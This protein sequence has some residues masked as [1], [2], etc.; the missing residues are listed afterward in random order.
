MGDEVGGEPG[1]LRTIKAQFN[2]ATVALLEMAL[3]AGV[4]A[5]FA[6]AGLVY[7]GVG[8]DKP[9]NESCKVGLFI[10]YGVC[11]AAAVWGVLFEPPRAVVGD[12]RRAWEMAT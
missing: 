2:K 5:A 11:A 10:V 8:V 7:C 3:A 4:S 1:P 12:V 6:L 9:E